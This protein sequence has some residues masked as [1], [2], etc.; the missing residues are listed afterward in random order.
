MTDLLLDLQVS[1]T[2]GTTR[3]LDAALREAIRSGRLG[4]GTRLPSTRALSSQLGV[5]RS[6]VVGVYEQLIAEGFLISRHGSGTTVSDVHVPVELL[7]DEAPRR[8][9]FRVNFLPGEPDCGSFP[10]TQWLASIRR[11]LTTAPD[12][13]FGYGDPQGLLELR[14]ALTTYLGRARGVLADPS[15]IVVFGGMASAVGVLAETFTSLSIT[16]VAVEDPGMPFHR[17]ILEQLGI[18]T[19]PVPVDAGGLRVDRLTATGAR[20]VLVSPAHQYPLGVSLPPERRTA[21][22]AWAREHDGWII[23]DDY[24]GEFRYDRQ[25]VGTLQGLDPERVIYAGTASK[26]LAPGLR[27]AWLALPRHLTRRVVT[28]RGYRGG[29]SQL[30]QAAL[31]DMIERGTFDA[32]VR[33]MRNVYRRRRDHLIERLRSD[34]PW[35]DVPGIPAGQHFTAHLPDGIDE[36]DLITRAAQEGIGLF[37]LALHRIQPG[38]A[39]LVIGFSRPPQHAFPSALDTLCEFLRGRTPTGP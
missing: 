2:A 5:A 9:R 26:S 18:T 36:Q 11:V 4:G 34:V 28:L 29:A 22:I 31:A 1:A 25:P 15:R 39:G 32:H 27:V 13:L 14:R 24:D 35:L 3:S 37:G 12:E 23:E 38:P 33:R 16:R 17:A 21:L 7:A 30:E 20:A 8:D 19:V 6:T 10:R